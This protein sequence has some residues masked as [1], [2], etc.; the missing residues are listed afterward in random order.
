MK[1][2]IIVLANKHYNT[3]RSRSI[4]HR[5]TFSPL[6]VQPSFDLINEDGDEEVFYEK[7]FY[8]PQHPIPNCW[9][10]RPPTWCIAGGSVGGIL[11]LIA[12]I[13]LLWLF[14]L[15][16]KNTSITPESEEFFRYT[17][18]SAFPLQGPSEAYVEV[19]R[20]DPRHNISDTNTN[21]NDIPTSGLS[22]VRHPVTRQ[23]GPVILQPDRTGNADIQALAQEVAAVLQNSPTAQRHQTAFQDRELPGQ[24]QLVVH[25]RG[26]H[27]YMLF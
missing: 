13:I 25:N 1:L 26:P 27:Y 20:V 3:N 9:Y 19:K 16:K 23:S 7:D 11:A 18:P 6:Y 12:L 22:P 8:Y 2:L 21:M 24:Q 15:R 17:Y 5:F 4:C 10:P 14:C